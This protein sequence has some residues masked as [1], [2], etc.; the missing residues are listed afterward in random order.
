MHALAGLMPA[1]FAPP[2]GKTAAEEEVETEAGF[3]NM[4]V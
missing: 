2:S 1:A 3:D 4:P